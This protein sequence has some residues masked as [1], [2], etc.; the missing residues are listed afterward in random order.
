[1]RFVD[2]SGIDEFINDYEF[3]LIVAGL[4]TIIAINQVTININNDNDDKAKSKVNL[5]INI[6]R[7]LGID[8]V[9]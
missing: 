8:N 9:Y 2:K 7:K 1:M 4:K 5:A 6:L 3:A